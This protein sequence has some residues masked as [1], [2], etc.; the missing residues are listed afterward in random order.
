MSLLIL[1]HNIDVMHQERNMGENIISTCM[2]FPSKTKD[3]MMAQQDLAEFCNHPSLKLLLIA[4]FKVCPFQW[5]A[6]LQ[7]GNAAE[8][9][10]IIHVFWSYASCISDTLEL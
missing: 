5:C 4:F 6:R 2:D 10:F 9:K 8:A 3:N 7:G 1:M